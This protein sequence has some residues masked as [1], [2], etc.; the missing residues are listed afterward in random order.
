[1]PSMPSSATSWLV[2]QKMLADNVPK[3]L[4]SSGAVLFRA[5]SG[6]IQYWT[7]LT[8]MVR[9]AGIV[10]AALIG[11]AAIAQPIGDHALRHFSDDPALA[12]QLLT[13][14]WRTPEDGT[15]DVLA[16]SGGG[17]NGAFGAGILA[18]WTE[19]GDRPV[20][21]HVTGVSTGALIA[22]FAYLGKDWDDPLRE[23]YLDKRTG[24]LM[25]RRLLSGL[26]ASSM[27]SGRPL[28]ELVDGYVTQDLVD[29]VAMQS[30]T[31]R[32]L[33]VVTTDL[34]EQKSVA[35][36]MGAVARLGGEEARA[37]FR[38]IVLASASIPGIFPPVSINVG[39]GDELHV[40]G[41]VAAPIYA[42]PEALADRQEAELQN[43][44]RLRIYMITNI[45]VAS[46][47]EPTESGAFAIL[48]RSLATS[49]KASMR[50]ALQMNAAVAQRYCADFGL[51]SIPAGQSV[52]L[53][54]FSQSAMLRLYDLGRSMGF[55]GYWRDRVIE[56]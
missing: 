55:D 21:D 6:F 45:S 14:V 30:M 7:V 46:A 12:E 4:V 22:P 38:D 5:A 36:D 56:P 49:G 28:R 13:N 15:F 9:A 44:G 43:H 19:R 24:K 11:A 20:F 18:G 33:I 2:L 35:W 37:L 27:Y 26:F 42:V 40:D 29:A 1:M 16:L 53:T 39:D 25:R 54:D 10:L 8:R 34:D 41:G 31:G 3:L 23:A 17:P 32:S 47:P 50:S 51:V 48:R 52:P